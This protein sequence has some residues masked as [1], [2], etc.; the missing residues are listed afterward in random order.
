MCS[1]IDGIVARS[2]ASRRAAPGWSEGRPRALAFLPRF[3]FDDAGPAWRY[4]L[5]AWPVVALPALALGWVSS[6]LA[7]D[8][9][10]P[11]V[12]GASFGV[13]AFAVVIVS[14]LV[15]TIVMTGPVVLLDRWLGPLPA[16]IG[17]AA[18]WG[19]AHS[20]AA[21]RWGLVIWW[22]F[23]IFSIAWLSWRGRGYW[24]AV[25]IVFAIH[26]LNNAGPIA[27]LLFAR[28]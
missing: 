14:P 5:F 11:S 7:P 17:S 15:E 25:G 12:A 26:A 28:A 18:I 9:A 20:L 8:L 22:P 27:V 2:D 13:V 1:T 21:A 19:V 4:I 10:G 3:L 6:K 24:R 23:L 16:V